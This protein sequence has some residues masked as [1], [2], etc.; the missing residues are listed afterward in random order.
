[1]PAL[2]RAPRDEG[3]AETRVGRGRAVDAAGVIAAA[4]ALS[5]LAWGWLLAC[6]GGFWRADRRLRDAPAPPRWPNVAVMIP[7]RDEA[8]TI[9]RV[10]GAHGASAYPGALTVILV[11]DGSTDGTARLAREAAARAA[12]AIHVLEAPPLPPGWTGKLHALATAEAAL[13]RLAPD[14]EWLLLT[15][16]DI[17]HAPDTLGRLV[18]HAEGRGLALASLMARLDARG[19]WGRLL[20]PAFV[21][22]FQ[23]LYPFAWINA[24]E[25]E[26]A[27][28]AGGCVLVSRA[29][30]AGIGG[31]AAIRGALIDDCTLAA[32]IKHGPPRRAIWLGLADREVVSLRD[33]RSLASLWAMVR[34]TAYAQLGHSPVRLAGAVAGMALVYLAG[35]VAVLSWPLHGGTAA[36]GLGAL[37]WGLSVRAYTPTLRLYG[38][39]GVRALS[40]PIAA[41]L[42]TGMTL[43]SARAHRAGRGGLWKGRSYPAP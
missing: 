32:R 15:D 21:F 4:A 30:L 10:L 33:N 19:V 37:A 20:V 12:R 1:M 24:P 42:Y 40:L 39:P 6:R 8:A 23:K 34:R 14:A 28:A 11:D 31:I 25:R 36:A 38:Q 2:V 27:G 22:F 35:P 13:P 7:A 3:G 16:A 43:D 17:A 41:L 29:A 18:A 9:A 26:T 5:A